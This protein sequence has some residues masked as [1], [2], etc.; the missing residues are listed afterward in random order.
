MSIFFFRFCVGYWGLKVIKVGV[1][2][3]FMEFMIKGGEFM[4]KIGR[5]NGGI[6]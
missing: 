4:I 1:V 3:V 2:F 5:G 6:L